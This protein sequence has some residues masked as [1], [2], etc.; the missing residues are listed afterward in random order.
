[1][2]FREILSDILVLAGLGLLVYAAFLIHPIAGWALSGVE[3]VGL[4]IAVG[5][6]VND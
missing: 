2:K 4:G 3:L 1:M 5:R 6:E